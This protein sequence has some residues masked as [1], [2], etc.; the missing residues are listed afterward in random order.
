MCIPYYLHCCKKLFLITFGTPLKNK[1]EEVFV[2]NM[3]FD[4]I[5]LILLYV[6]NHNAF[7]KKKQ[8]RKI[9]ELLKQVQ[10]KILEKYQT[11]FG[12]EINIQLLNPMEHC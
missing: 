12:G 10:D 8:I 11:G 6:H 3:T 1:L 2:L 9:N 4:T 5:W 7:K